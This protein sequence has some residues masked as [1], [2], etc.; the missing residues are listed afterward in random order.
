MVIL[1][2]DDYYKIKTTD[3]KTIE[4]NQFLSLKLQIND[5][6][7]FMNKFTNHVGKMLDPPSD[8]ILEEHFRLQIQDHPALKMYFELYRE[9]EPD[10]PNKSYAKMLQKLERLFELET[11]DKKRAEMGFGLSGG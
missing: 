6:R 9:M 10:D 2:L 11:D 7:D 8:Y 4:L 3:R 5:L 1:I